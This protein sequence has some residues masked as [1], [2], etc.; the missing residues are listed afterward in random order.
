[1]KAFI[2]FATASLAFFLAAPTLAATSYTYDALGR[3]STVT[4]D[5]GKQIVYTYD[6]AGNRTQVVTQT[7]TNQPPTAVPDSV[8]INSNT[9]VI[10]H[11]LANDTDPDGDVLAIQSLSPSGTLGAPV[12][13]G[14]GTTVTFT[15]PL[16]YSGADSFGYAITDG[17]GHVASAPVTVTIANQPPMAVHDA[18]TVALGVPTP[19]FVLGNDTDPEQGPLSITS[20]TTPSH[21]TTTINAGQS[22]TYATVGGNTSPDGFNYS[23]VDDHGNT[24]HAT[25][26]VTITGSNSAPVARDDQYGINDNGFPVTPQGQF[27]PRT[28]DTDADGDPLTIISVT[29]GTY[30]NVGIVDNGTA[31]TY[32]YNT[33]V[34][35]PL[36]QTDQ[37]TYTISDG[38][39]G[40]A[41]ATVAVVIDVESNN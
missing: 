16:N 41:T 32:I 21:G 12:I 25:V 30:G 17:H 1:M 39:G 4:Y 20:V 15:P 19:I 3:V 22:I 28:N 14:S 7:G 8:T 35:S 24:A 36:Q 23:I 9:P 31:V 29:Q 5:G 6:S 33:V 34:T 2:L 27:D 10:V 13:T 26:S 40:T 18:P 38:N 37:F 11:V